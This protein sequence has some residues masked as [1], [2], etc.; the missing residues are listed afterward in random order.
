MNGY[1]QSL[2][3]NSNKFLSF[4]NSHEYDPEKKEEYNFFMK[5]KNVL[6]CCIVSYRIMWLVFVKLYEII[7]HKDI[8]LMNG[9]I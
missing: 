7:K 2:F 5:I 4:F 6:N 9:I 3:D 1:T 8:S